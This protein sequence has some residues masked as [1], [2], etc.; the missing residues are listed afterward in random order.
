MKAGL[1]LLVAAAIAS[2]VG[3]AGCASWPPSAP[4]AT[5]GSSD[6]ALGSGAGGGAPGRNVSDSLLLPADGAPNPDGTVTATILGSDGSQIGYVDF[7]TSQGAP[8][9]DAAGNTLVP[10]ALIAVSGAQNPL[11]PSSPED[12]AEIDIAAADVVPGAVMT[13]RAGALLFT[14]T[15]EQANVV[16]VDGQ[17]FL[18]PSSLVVRIDVSVLGA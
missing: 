12:S 5:R 7:F 10:D 1:R 13:A 14:E 17:P 16:P 3:V 9:T 6:P 11:D 2:C 15:V 18:D 8:V 4:V